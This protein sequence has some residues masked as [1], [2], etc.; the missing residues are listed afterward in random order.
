MVAIIR[1]SKLFP[2]YDCFNTPC[3][4]GE[5]G[6]GGINPDIWFYW[7]TDGIDALAL[8]VFSRNYPKTISREAADILS[9]MDLMHR[10]F[11]SMHQQGD[12]SDCTIL[13]M[14]RCSLSTRGFID[15][16]LGRKKSP[17]EEFGDETQFEQPEAFWQE[18]ERLFTEKTRRKKDNTEP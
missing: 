14:G 5:P 15:Y 4:H 11:L 9:G 12:E 6:C 18:M 3:I 13:P 8:Q 7:V 16:M 10:G 1:G 17:L 2:G